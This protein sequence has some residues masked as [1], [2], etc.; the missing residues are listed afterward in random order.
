MVTKIID[1]INNERKKQN[2]TFIELSSKT[3]ISRKHLSFIFNKKTNPTI[4]II[5]KL[6]NAL[7]MSLDVKEIR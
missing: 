3:G 6:A 5:S 1:E 2:I 7:G 4:D